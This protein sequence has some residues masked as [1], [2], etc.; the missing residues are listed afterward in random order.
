MYVYRACLFYVYCSDYVGGCG[1]VCVRNVM[2]VVF[3]VFIVTR[4]ATG[5]RLWEA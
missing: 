2:D 3:S 1:T 4:G 5:A